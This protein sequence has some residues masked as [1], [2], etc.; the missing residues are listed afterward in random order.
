MG[1]PEKKRP[2]PR[3][4]PKRTYDHLL[5][6]IRAYRSSGMISFH[7]PGHKNRAGLLP[8]DLPYAIDMTESA[9]MADLYA[10]AGPLRSAMDALR[11]F[12][13]TSASY[14][15]FNGST[16]GILA[17]LRSLTRPGDSVL[18]GRNAH[19]SV[20]QALSLLRLHPYFI[21]PRYEE[22]LPLF[23]DIS[24]TRVAE[25][26]DAH[27]EI[28]LVLITSPTYE[29]ICSDL[30]AIAQI[31]RKKHCLLM[32]DQAHGAHLAY[33][34]RFSDQRLPEAVDA[35]ADL[36]VESLHKTL[37]ALTPAA[38]VHLKNPRYQSALEEN[39][40]LF[41]SSSPSHIVLASIDECLT[42]LN[43]EGPRLFQPFLERL[44]RFREG[45]QN[46]HHLFLYQPDLPMD[47]FKLL[48]SCSAIE[49]SAQ[50]VTQDL[51]QRG[52]A[53][54]MTLVNEILAM[55]SLANQKKDLDKLLEALLL[56]DSTYT[57]SRKR[58]RYPL[59]AF[60][61]QRLEPDEASWAK[62]DWVPFEKSAGLIAGEALW[63][64]P[65]GI[66]LIWPGEEITPEWIETVRAWTAT[67][68]SFRT[69]SQRFP[70]AFCVL[71]APAKDR[72][73][74]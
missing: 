66:P 65:P 38:L 54:E 22:G 46:L 55:P 53:F 16:A 33:L 43:E 37:P 8:A 14:F 49:E 62:K 73:A 72:Q 28:R 19:R 3:W 32:V 21:L 34:N 64:Y 7:M 18:I 9:N 4:D 48:L 29:G 17:G 30:P 50:K 1:G 36:V 70:D 59:P 20:Y 12:R 2:T 27:P 40:A 24:P 6:A 25:A 52:F 45:A 63:A 13:G 42:Y 35:G 61:P 10:P 26:L 74:D 5:D 56:L 15:L 39:L 71:A 23:L 47:P 51:Y 60:P 31:C 58:P 11:R 68:Q 69:T 41:Q 57:P 67:G 44:F